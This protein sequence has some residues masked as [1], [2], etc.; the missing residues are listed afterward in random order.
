MK[1]LQYVA[2]L[3]HPKWGVEPE[4]VGPFDTLSAAM[5]WGKAHGCPDYRT[6]TPPERWEARHAHDDDFISANADAMRGPLVDL[7]HDEA[8]IE[9]AVQDYTADHEQYKVGLTLVPPKE[10]RCLNCEVVIENEPILK[11]WGF[12]TTSCEKE[13]REDNP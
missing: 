5:A 13:Y 10:A 4:Y 1:R 11:S 8:Y 2:V 12:C 3:P 9:H 6:I 7:L